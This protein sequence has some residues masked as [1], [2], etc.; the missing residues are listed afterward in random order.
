MRYL[1]IVLEPI[2]IKGDPEDEQQLQADV[3]ER[4]SA[5]IESETLAFSIDEEDE[6]DDGDY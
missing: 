6:D 4:L 3:Y 5:M 2:K 1:K